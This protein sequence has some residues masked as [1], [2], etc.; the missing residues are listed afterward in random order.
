[1]TILQVMT[2]FLYGIPS[3]SKTLT[4]DGVCLMSYGVVIARWSKGRILMPETDVF[5]AERQKGIEKK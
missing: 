1:M 2:R 4:T 3:W 5:T